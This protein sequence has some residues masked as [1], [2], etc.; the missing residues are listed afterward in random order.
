MNSLPA[1]VES[2]RLSH[3]PDVRALGS[4]LMLTLR[5]HLRGRRLLAL[6]L[7]LVMPAVLTVVINLTSRVGPP[8]ESLKFAFLYNLIPHALAP[9]VA[10][11]YAAG[12]IRDD[13]EDQTLTYLLLRPLPRF[14]IYAVKLLATLVVTSALLAVFSGITL[15]AIV[16]TAKEPAVEGTLAEG[17]KIAGV[18]ALA[19]VGYCGVFGLMGLLMRRSLFVGVAYIFLFEGLLASLDTMARRLTVMYYF[20]VLV[21]RWLTPASGNDW[22]IPLKTAPEASA[23]AWTLLCAGFVLTTAG[24]LLF[25]AREFRAKT[26]EGD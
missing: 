1:A 6:S 26:P 2:P 20:R 15:A 11:L 10:L 3:W 9:L 13:V 12:V 22:S 8:A 19:Q 25:A 4:L 21:L 5:Q 16:W 18:L 7:L 17:C 24:A 23:C 14:A